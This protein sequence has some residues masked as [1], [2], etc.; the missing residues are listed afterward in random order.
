MHL[1]PSTRYQVLLTINNALVNQTSREALFKALAQEIS[2]IIAF[3]R[4]SINLYDESQSSLSYFATAEGITPEAIEGDSRPLAKG[5]IAKT[6]IRSKEPLVIPDLKKHTFWPSV[7]A[8]V[9]AG[10]NATMAF[11]LITRSNVLGSIHLSFRTPPDH[12]NELADFLKELSGQVAIAVDNMLAHSELTDL[13]RRLQLQKDFLLKQSE[14]IY[15]PDNFFYV[16]TAMQNLMGQIQMISETDAS[17]LLTGETGTGKDY[18]ARFI[19]SLS[20]RQSGLFVKVNCPGLASTLFESELFGHAKGAFTGA[21]AKRVGR[22]EM[23]AGGTLFLDEIGDLPAPQQAKLLHVLQDKTFERVG[24]NRPIKA[25]FRVIA[26]TNIDMEQAI[27]D[28]TFREDLYYRLNTVSLHIPPLRERT[29]DIPLLLD[30]LTATESV[31]LNRPAP[32]FAPDAVDVLMAYTWPGNVREL[33]NLVKR[34]II[35]HPGKRL[36]PGIVQGMLQTEQ[37]EN[38]N[39]SSFPSLAEMEKQHIEKALELSGGKVGGSGSA[40]QLLGIP[41]STLQYR[42]KKHGV[43]NSV[44]KA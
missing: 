3:D 20:P 14:N 39:A 5:S 31:T 30:R 28:D 19:H 27:R 35:L 15:D 24:D 16:S 37:T 17:V 25:D 43:G 1:N 13:N 34:L 22:L 23:A 40:A 38:D 44:D 2:K 7:Q 26:A 33:K 4:F 21:H 42:M 29:D 36:G 12:M 11:P 10:L 6:V 41:R 32:E 18:I 8:M 9:D